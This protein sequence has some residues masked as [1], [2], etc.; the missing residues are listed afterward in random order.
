MWEKMTTFVNNH[1]LNS[2]HN[3]IIWNLNLIILETLQSH[4]EK[5]K[6]LTNSSS[7]VFLN[8]R[9]KKTYNRL[10]HTTNSKILVQ[11]Q[12]QKHWIVIC[13]KNM[14]KISVRQNAKLGMLRL[15]FLVKH[16][17]KNIMR[18][19]NRQLWFFNSK[20]GEGVWL[21][22]KFGLMGHKT[23][24][25]LFLGFCDATRFVLIY[26]NFCVVC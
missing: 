13:K 2:C 24:S 15:D 14:I 4:R 1:F 5:W 9:G 20:K 12:K 23:L 16:P 26:N 22:F 18:I 8:F 25:I 10:Q 19:E 21:V 3:Y 17:P 6:L 7:Q 11:N